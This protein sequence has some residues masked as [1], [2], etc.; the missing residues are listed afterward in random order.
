MYKKDQVGNVLSLN[1]V[2]IKHP[3]NRW[4]L[5]MA[6]QEARDRKRGLWK[7]I[8]NC[9]QGVESIVYIGMYSQEL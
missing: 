6:Y 9:Q 7:H 4:V 1:S 2:V 3:N 8:N 5:L